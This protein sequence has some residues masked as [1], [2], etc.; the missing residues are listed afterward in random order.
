[1]G[2]GKEYLKPIG[3][4]GAGLCPPPRF[5]FFLNLPPSAPPQPTPYPCAEHSL[6]R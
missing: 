6:N 2:L 3:A 4:V 1:M 5:Q